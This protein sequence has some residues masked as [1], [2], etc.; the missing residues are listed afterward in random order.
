MPQMPPSQ[1]SKTWYQ[2]NMER[3]L[4]RKTWCLG[5]LRNTP[6]PSQPVGAWTGKTE[7][8][9]RCNGPGT[10]EGRARFQVPL[11]RPGL[12]R[13]FFS[14][15]DLGLQVHQ[16]QVAGTPGQIFEIDVGGDTW[17]IPWVKENAKV[18]L[19]NTPV[20]AYLELFKSF[21]EFT[22]TCYLSHIILRVALE[23]R[24]LFW[25]K[26]NFWFMD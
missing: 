11:K 7:C 25:Q 21:S 24:S 10:V 17:L 1:T 4:A 16:R 26:K 8:N 5:K 12:K 22:I 23:V 14:C 9:A 19:I 2:G 20:R 6:S 15:Q 18:N 3:H 13:D